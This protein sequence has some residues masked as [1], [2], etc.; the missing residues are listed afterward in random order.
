MSARPWRIAFLNTHPIQYFSPM[1]ASL[2]MSEEFEVTVIYCSDWSLRGAEDS[3]FG[4]KV[5]WDI[6]LL[7]GYEALFL[8]ERA[9]VRTPSG[10]FSLVC[11]EIFSVIWEGRFDAL[12]VHGHNYFVNLL[13]ILAARIVGTR[14]FMRGDTNIHLQSK[15]PAARLKNRLKSVLYRSA[16]GCLA[17][18]TANR[19]FYRSLGVPA[20]QIY[21]MPFAV[22]NERFVAGATIEAE[23][24]LNFRGDLGLEEESTLILFSSKLQKQKRPDD[25]IRAV[26]ILEAKGYRLS[27]LIVG[28]GEMYSELKQMVLDLQL[29]NVVFTGFIN[30][31]RLPQVFGASDIFVLP[32]SNDQWGLVVNEAMCA[33]LPVVVA[34]GVGCV[35]D[36]LHDGENGF[37]VKAGDIEG[38][39][40]ALEILL[41]DEVKRRRMGERSLEIIK[42]WSFAECR[43]GL[44]EALQG[45][46]SVSA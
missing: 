17:I 42:G 28:S 29:Q 10:F 7:H 25:L 45:R 37:M 23:A 30:Q 21:L 22:D 3:G 43:A 27:L 34:D 41:G 32:S 9:Q 13:A 36:L 8:G 46:A 16:D 40:H 6:D 15:S 1:Y 26:A 14:V 11:P 2:N 12:V 39:A 20:D 38:L 18:G 31:A 44:L 19:K 35:Y 4:Q 5:K 33:Q 24:R